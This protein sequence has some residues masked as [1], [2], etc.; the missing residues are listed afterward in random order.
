MKSIG[1]FLATAAVMCCLS[2]P[3]R[4]EIFEDEHGWVGTDESHYLYVEVKG[5]FSKYGKHNCMVLISCRSLGV[6][7]QE[8]SMDVASQKE[9]KQE[10]LNQF[11]A[12]YGPDFDICL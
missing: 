9:C 5:L 4:A 2:S 12:L 10:S 8:I 1:V 7:Q 11:T 6:F 3:S